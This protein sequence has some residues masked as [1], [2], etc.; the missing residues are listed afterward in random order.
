MKATHAEEATPH[1]CEGGGDRGAHRD[2]RGRKRERMKAMHVVEATL[3]KE[4]R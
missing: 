2:V 1:T 3:V 4:N